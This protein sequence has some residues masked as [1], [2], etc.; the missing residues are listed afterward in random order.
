MSFPILSFPILSFPILQDGGNC[1]SN[2]FSKSENHE[3][4]RS[5]SQIS[6]NFVG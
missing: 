2:N 6:A 4:C 5:V 3:F 1:K